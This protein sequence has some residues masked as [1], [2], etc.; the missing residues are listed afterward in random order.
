VRGV[1]AA[2]DRHGLRGVIFGHAGDAHVHVNPL[3]DV[4][5]PNW[6]EAVSAVL[7]EVVELTARL[8]GTLAGEHGDGRLRTPL[9]ARTW[10]REA[11]LLFELV[12]RSFDPT[13]ILNPGVKVPVDGQT[14]LG[15]VKYDPAIEALPPAARRALDTVA[16]ERAYDRLR[17]ELLDEASGAASTA[18]RAGAADEGAARP[19][20]GATGTATGTATTGA[21]YEGERSGDETE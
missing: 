10:S 17:L 13:G 11:T 2:L 8:D 1:R 4:G 12:K 16:E 3:V 21:E 15:P 20:A 14:A 7:D 18:G 6:R 19:A 5:R 9:L